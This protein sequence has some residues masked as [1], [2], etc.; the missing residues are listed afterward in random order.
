MDPTEAFMSTMTTGMDLM[1]SCLNATRYPEP[2]HVEYR[3]FW[4][5][6]MVFHTLLIG[7]NPECLQ[8]NFSVL[9]NF[10]DQLKVAWGVDIASIFIV[11]M[12]LALAF[13]CLLLAFGTLSLVQW[14][15]Q[16]IQLSLE[17]LGIIIKIL[18]IPLLVI[19]QLIQFAAPKIY[20]F[21]TEWHL[22]PR[23]KRKP[24]V[25]ELY[26]PTVI[27]TCPICHETY[28]HLEWDLSGYI[29]CGHSFCSACLRGTKRCPMCNVGGKVRKLFIRQ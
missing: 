6:L 15:L 7:L 28:A 13:T 11:W 23:A 27:P 1:G 24:G 9:S 19:W 25:V 16:L 12:E 10:F 29:E 8:C 21:Y 14:A 17:S 22:I 4:E 18:S 3:W 2:C 20:D 26:N 5:T